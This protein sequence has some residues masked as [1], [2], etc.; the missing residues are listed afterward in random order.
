M[1]AVT[2]ESRT[3]R[4]KCGRAKSDLSGLSIAIVTLLMLLSLRPALGGSFQSTASMSYTRTEHTATLL[5]N[6]KVLVAGGSEGNYANASAELY[7]FVTSHW[8]GTG[9]MSTNRCLH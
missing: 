8:T 5:P 7:D 9:S 1:I 3:P 4:V 2:H 6:G